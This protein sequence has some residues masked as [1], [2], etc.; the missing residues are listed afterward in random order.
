[1]YLEFQTVKKI[2]RNLSSDS[3]IHHHQNPLDSKYL[4]V[5]SLTL[6]RWAMF[7]NLPVVHLLKNFW[8]FY[9]TRRFISMFTRALHWSL[10]W[11][12]SIQYIQSHPTFL[13]C[14]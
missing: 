5:N 12:T 11:A 3:V 1:L 4:D 8:T 13:R 14:I 9:R 7:D 2:P 10:S 6:W